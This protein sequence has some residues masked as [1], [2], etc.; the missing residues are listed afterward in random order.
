MTSE[1]PFV[2]RSAEKLAFLRELTRRAA[3]NPQRDLIHYS[4]QPSIGKTTLARHVHRWCRQAPDVHS[5]LLNL[6]NRERLGRYERLLE[7]KH[8]LASVNPELEF[9]AFEYARTRYAAAWNYGDYRK[10][11]S[12]LEYWP[13]KMIEASVTDAF[14]EGGKKALEELGKHLGLAGSLTVGAVTSALSISIVGAAAGLAAGGA[15]TAA[16][17]ATWYWIKGLEKKAKQKKLLK[18]YPILAP[19]QQIK[20][21]DSELHHLAL[22]ARVLA[23]CVNSDARANQYCFIIDPGNDMADVEGSACRELAVTLME[24]FQT[25]KAPLV[26]TTARSD[27]AGWQSRALGPAHQHFSLQDHK[28]PKLNLQAIKKDL[29]RLGLTPSDQ[30]LRAQNNE[31]DPADLA[32]WWASK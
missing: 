16:F 31:V 25:L 28:L 2:G 26:V 9:D 23:T 15:S 19:F 8:R 13:E 6:E 14:K 11:L 1:P 32:R 3:P 24:L 17:L 12:A 21:T 20:D 22:L 4:G 27:L 10:E 7:I 5:V 18:R 30:D 29:E